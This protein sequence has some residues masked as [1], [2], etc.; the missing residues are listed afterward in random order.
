MTQVIEKLASAAQLDYFEVLWAER[1]DAEFPR[2]Q[3]AQRTSTDV[4]ALIRRAMTKPALP[5]SDEVSDEIVAL[6]QAL[7]ITVV[8]APDRARAGRQL[9]DLQKRTNSKVWNEKLAQADEEL[10]VLLAG[11]AVAAAANTSDDEVPF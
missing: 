5:V 6:S 9:R 3:F 2:E 4:S 8:V 10:D 7:G 11:G 1:S